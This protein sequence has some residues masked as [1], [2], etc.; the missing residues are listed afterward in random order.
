MILHF[1]YLIILSL[2]FLKFLNYLNKIFLINILI[3]LLIQIVLVSF[4]WKDSIYINYSFCLFINIA[5]AFI[6]TGLSHSV[7]LLI[8]NEIDKQK[9]ISY[10]T[11]NDKIIS[12]SFKNRINNLIFKRIIKKNGKYTLSKKNVW[13]VGIIKKIRK[14]LNISVYG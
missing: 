3:N 9:S 2:I 4:I 1:I 6:F 8:L 5:F 11:I 13:K 12:L 7:S 10:N 14:I